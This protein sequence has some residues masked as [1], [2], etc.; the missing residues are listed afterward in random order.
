MVE[1]SDRE[2][3]WTGNAQVEDKSSEN[4]KERQSQKEAGAC[5][6]TKGPKAQ[7]QK[8]GDWERKGR[9]GRQTRRTRGQEAKLEKSIK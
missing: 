3:T 2:V 6:E 7:R 8:G 9:L 1:S 5:T 4:E